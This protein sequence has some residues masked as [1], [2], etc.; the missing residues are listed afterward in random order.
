MIGAIPVGPPDTIRDVAHEVDKLVVLLTPE[1]FYAVGNF[2][3]DFTQV[4]DRDVLRYLKL[5]NEALATK[6]FGGL[7]GTDRGP[8][9]HSQ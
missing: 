9:I 1:P 7:S 2:Y 4:E 8:T 6:Q 3:E 5:A